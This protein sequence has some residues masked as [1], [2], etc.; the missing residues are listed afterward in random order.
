MQGKGQTPTRSSMAALLAGPVLLLGAVPLAAQS[1]SDYR[2]PGATASP[3][4]RAAGPVDPTDPSTLPRARPSAA[5]SSPPPVAA[6]PAPTPSASPAPRAAAPVPRASATPRPMPIRA[7][8]PTLMPPVPAQASPQP[9][10][11]G[12]PPPSAAAS[13][14]VPLPAPTLP[15]IM[16]TPQANPAPDAAF[17][18]RLW[19]AAGA[20]LLAAIGAWLLWR[21]RGRAEEIEF[22]P[23]VV[24][25]PE[26]QPEPEPVQAAQPPRPAPP[27]APAPPAVPAAPAASGLT[28]TL[29]ARRL[30]ASLMATTLSYTLR[31]TNTAA[32]PLA[33]VAVEGDLVS[34]HSSLPVERQIASDAHRL[35][36]RHAAVS[37]APGESVEFTGDM[38]LPLDQITPIRAGDA[39]YFVPLARFRIESG[40]AGAAAQVQVQTYVIGDLPEQDGAALRP[41]RLDLGPRT[42]SRIGQRAVA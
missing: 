30:T 34:A 16:P 29:E 32:T 28:L 18:W 7:A 26:P 10:P 4:S 8:A 22:E 6:S 31:L 23:P 3:T 20:A 19:A 36:L 24:P 2:L 41:F 21:R 39:A 40:G 35:E 37:L 38:R 33:D 27:P 14:A 17:D 5:P 9:A 15:A 42:Y 12:P 1:A 11:I 13:E 25:A